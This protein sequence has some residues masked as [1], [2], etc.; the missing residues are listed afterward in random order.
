[1][2]IRE[3]AFNS[4]GHLTQNSIQ[5]GASVRYAAFI[6]S[7]AFIRSFTVSYYKRFED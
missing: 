3:G 4:E 5:K 7:W 6:G 1:M 2:S